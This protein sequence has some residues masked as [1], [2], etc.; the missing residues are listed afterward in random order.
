MEITSPHQ[1][2]N[3]ILCD[4]CCAHVGIDD[5]FCTNCGYPLKGTEAEQRAFIAKQATAEIDLRDYH[6]KLKNATNTLYYLAGI[7]VLSALIIYFVKSD[8]PNILAVVITNLI[9]AMLF[10]ALGG[11]SQKKPLACLISGFCLYI[12]VQ[13]LIFVNDPAAIFSGIIVKI[14][15]IGFLVK[16]IRSAFQVDKIKNNIT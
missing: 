9:L 7:F 11:Y 2:N 12:L 16:G 6:K 15:I 5:Q 13:V 10:L 3:L 14:F 8:D 1:S 4:A